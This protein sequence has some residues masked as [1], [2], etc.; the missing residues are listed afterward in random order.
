MKKN[1]TEKGPKSL[2]EDDT[3]GKGITMARFRLK[4]VIPGISFVFI[5]GFFIY[6][7]LLSI[8]QK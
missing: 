1:L 7:Y 4:I 6:G 8:Q 2:K 3:D 5:M